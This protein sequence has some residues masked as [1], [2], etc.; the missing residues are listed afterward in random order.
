MGTNG[1]QNANEHWYLATLST[2]VLAQASTGRQPGITVAMERQ[3]QYVSSFSDEQLREFLDLADVHHVAVRAIQQIQQLAKASNFPEVGTRFD[4][5]LSLENKRIE[6]ALKFLNA[7]CRELDDAGCPVTVIKSLDHWPDLGGDLDLYSSGDRD[8]VISVFTKY[9]KAEL[10]PQ[11]WGDKLANKWNF[12]IPGLPE[13]VECHVKWLG[14]TGEQV[15]LATRLEN[16]RVQR[17]IANYV[18]PVPAPEERIIVS[19]LQRMYRHFYIRLCD[20]VNITNLLR[21]HAVDFAELRQTAD[22]G[23]IWPGVAT[24]LRIVSEYVHSYTNEVFELPPE[25][26]SAA[27]FS[28]ERTYVSKQ[29]LRIPIMPEAAELYTKQMIGIG[30]HRNFRAMFR[31]SLLPALATAAFVGYRLTGSDKGIW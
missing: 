13:L 12:R 30:A 16:R 9:F 14:Q 6:N 7:I 10:E 5:A 2:L 29:F 20:I 8:A 19:T 25:V 26:Q 23:S 1:L 18:F 17:S 4:A 24:L 27:R 11:S 31:L 3:L 21:S 15:A 22:L 28:V